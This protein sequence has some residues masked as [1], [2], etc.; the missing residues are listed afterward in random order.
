MERSPLGSWLT[1]AWG[2]VGTY[3]ICL[4]AVKALALLL[5]I[6]LP[7]HCLGKSEFRK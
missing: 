7:A 4:P 1:T 3:T 5:C 6:L 2:S